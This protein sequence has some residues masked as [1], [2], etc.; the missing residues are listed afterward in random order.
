MLALFNPIQY[1]FWDSAYF[2]PFSIII[3]DA[4]LASLLLIV[5]RL[6]VKMA[7]VEIKNPRSERKQVVIY[8]AGEAGNITKRTLDRDGETRYRV[9]AFID[10][11][12]KK[13]GKRMDGVSIFHTDKLDELLRSNRNENLIISIQNPRISN[14]RRVIEA[15]LK[16]QTQVLNVPPV[17]QWINGELSF[18]QHTDGLL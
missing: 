10:D 4:I 9:V 7:Y 11:D 14:R 13:Q 12:A 16:H 1:F 8:G 17:N 5:F 2:L 15:A 6:A 18:N 3:I